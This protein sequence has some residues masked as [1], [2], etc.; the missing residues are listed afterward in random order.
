MNKMT[1]DEIIQLK[2]QLENKISKAITEA[3]LDYDFKLGDIDI[4]AKVARRIVFLESGEE[5][6][7]ECI[8]FAD[9]KFDLLSDYLN[10]HGLI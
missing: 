1:L 8:T 3:L 9:V 7:S 2:A 4:N 10:G 5:L 6:I